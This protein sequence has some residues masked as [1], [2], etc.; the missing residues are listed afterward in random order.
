MRLHGRATIVTGASRGIGRAI[1]GL[2]AKE[3]AKVVVNYVKRGNE[4]SSLA[5]EINSKGGQAITI[6]A[7][8]SRADEVRKMVNLT[9]AEFGRIDVLVNNA[10]IIIDAGFLDSTEE[11]WNKTMNV[12]LK[13]PY[14]C[15]KEVA[16]IMLRQKSGKIV[17]I[18][19]IAGL[20]H[21][22]AVTNAV[23]TA[24]KAGLIGLTRSLAVN[25]APT[26]NVNAICPGYIETDMSACDTPE[27]RRRE[28]EDA[29]L[30]RVAKPEEVAYAAL[31]L[32]SSESDFIT[33]EI[34]TVSG[35]RAMR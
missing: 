14:L 31:F 26:I 32:A 13:G 29:L 24:S 10:G 19:S 2:F 34:L 11:G 33:G 12:N 3:G 35:G 20:A 1:A 5:E 30:N 9:M 23:Y 28:M 22:T 27:A 6:R 17:N 8:V 21:R 15:S 4:A 18:S 7:D 25:L 16:P